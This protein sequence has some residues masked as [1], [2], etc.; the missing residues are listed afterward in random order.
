MRGLAVWLVVA[1]AG[2]GGRAAPKQPVPVVQSELDQAEAAERMRRHDIAREHYE[3]AV[4]SARDPQSVGIAN[5]EFAET[6]ATW[7]EYDQSIAHY[8]RAVAATPGDPQAWNDLGLVRFKVGNVAGA[9]TALERARGLAPGDFRPRRNLAAAL[10]ASGDKARAA[11]EYRAML[12][13]DL[14]GPLRK[15]VEWALEQLAKP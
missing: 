14:P 12:E 15:K 10:W 8:E 4:A 11:A 9:V 6:L 13:L 5:R 2:C 1:C 7:G 3:R